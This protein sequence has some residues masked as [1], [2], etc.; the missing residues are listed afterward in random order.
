MANSHGI[1]VKRNDYHRRNRRRNISMHKHSHGYSVGDK[2]LEK[3]ANIEVMVKVV[4][5]NALI[6]LVRRNYLRLHSD[7]RTMPVAVLA[8]ECVKYVRHNLTNYDE[9]NHTAKR[10]DHQFSSLLSQRTLDAI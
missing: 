3:I 8:R 10:Y 1:G 5:R 6:E 9:L 4:D 2:H 7:A